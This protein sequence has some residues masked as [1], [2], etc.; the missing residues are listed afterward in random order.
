[1]S[2]YTIEHVLCQL[3]N[4]KKTTEGYKA[5]CPCHDDKTPSLSIKQGDRKVLLHC[6]AGCKYEEIAKKLQIKTEVKSTALEYFSSKKNIPIDFLKSLHITEAHSK[7]IIPYRYSNNKSARSRERYANGGFI[8]EVEKK[9]IIIYGLWRDQKDYCI[10][11]E[12]ESDCWTL[13]Y[14]NFNAL[15]VPGSTMFKLIKLEQ[16]N[17]FNDIIIIEESDS[18]GKVFAFQTKNHLRKIG[19]KGKIYIIQLGYKD[20]SEMYLAEDNFKEELDCIINEVKAKKT[21]LEEAIE[22]NP[23]PTF[24]FPSPFKEFIEQCSEAFGCDDAFVATP[25]L[26]LLSSIVGGS[27][28]INITG[29]WFESASLYIALIA[30]PG[31]MKTPIANFIKSFISEITTSLDEKNAQEENRFEKDSIKYKIDLEIYKAETKGGNPNFPFPDQVAPKIMH[32]FFL[33]DTTTEALAERLYYNPK[34]ILLFKDELVSWITSFNQYK[35]GTGS[36]KQFFLSAWSNSMTSVARKSKRTKITNKPYLVVYGAI[37][38]DQLDVFTKQDNDGFIDRILFSFPKPFMKTFR[39]YRINKNILVG[40]QNRI[41]DF[42]SDEMEETFTVSEEGI[43][44]FEDWC[45]RLYEEAFI[46]EGKM[47]GFL[48]KYHGQAGAIT[49][50][51]AYINNRKEANVSDVA[52]AILAVEYFRKCT[53]NI[54]KKEKLSKDD[55]LIKKIIEYCKAKNKKSISTRD[56]VRNNICNIQKSIKAF[57]LLNKM[58]KYNLGRLE[59]KKFIFY[60]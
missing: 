49:L 57:D 43:L 19:Y 53:E 41:T 56:I 28:K 52:H 26:A 48:N 34:G 24:I 22:V 39:S 31:S 58:Q 10:I 18:A 30:Q 12:G 21:C 1:M 47:K 45:N 2:Y 36:D 50:I 32:D 42:Y 29:E 4:V 11:V 16:L 59:K 60:D 37:P 17:Q 20:A 40:I 54:F 46:E 35:G 15:G 33:E 8:W 13:W 23:F 3:E 9:E 44:Y 25:I 5:S 14:N 38:P 7:L 27:K 55:K 6:F 51:L